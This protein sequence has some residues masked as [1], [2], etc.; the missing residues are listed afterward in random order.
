[1]RGSCLCGSVTYDITPPLKTFQYC[2]CARCRKV[3]GSAHAANIF[4]PPAQF[5]WLSGEG[6]VGRFEVSDAKYFATSFCKNCGSSMPWAVQGGK[7]IV[8]PAGTLDEEPGIEPQQNIFWGSRAPWY[9]ETCDMNKFS[10]L[11]TKSKSL[12]DR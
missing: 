2:H 6:L 12:I 3:T 9:K 11:P 4:V 5:Q 1:M 10:A 7:N 8:V